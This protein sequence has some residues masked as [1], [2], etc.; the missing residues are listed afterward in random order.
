MG[1]AVL[2]ILVVGVVFAFFFKDVFRQVRN[3]MREAESKAIRAADKQA[4]PERRARNEKKVFELYL[5]EVTKREI[6]R[7][8][9]P[10]IELDE[11]FRDQKELDS[12]EGLTKKDLFNSFNNKYRTQKIY[13]F[14]PNEAESQ[15]LSPSKRDYMYDTNLEF[16]GNKYHVKGKLISKAYGWTK[17]YWLT[18][19]EHKIRWEKSRAGLGVGG[20]DAWE[21]I[22]QT[23]SG[24]YAAVLLAFMDSR[25]DE[26]KA[27]SKVFEG[28]KIG[29]QVEA[30]GIM[31]ISNTRKKFKPEAPREKVSEIEYSIY[32]DDIHTIRAKFDEIIV[33]P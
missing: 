25:T 19:E 30:T 24:E 10:I 28:F 1:G 6:E 7:E 27:Q 29:S 21:L 33:T 26:A 17:T 20:G 15:D 8:N 31:S 14:V 2:A 5:D 13:K 32:C 3:N 23:D 9:N 16:V 22:L 18:S 4:A 12:A 11:Y